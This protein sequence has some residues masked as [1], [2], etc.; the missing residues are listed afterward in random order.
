MTSA[1]L[2][3]FEIRLSALLT[4]REQEELTGLSSNRT[5]AFADQPLTV[6]FLDNICPEYTIQYC[7]TKLL[8]LLFF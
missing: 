4:D 3:G 8:L 6:L 1:C 2:I 5:C 7:S